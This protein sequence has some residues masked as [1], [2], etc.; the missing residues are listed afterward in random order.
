M[1]V[2]SKVTAVFHQKSLLDYLAGRF[3][4]QTREIWRA[5]IEAGEVTCNGRSAI[6]DQ[7]VRQGDVIACDLPEPPLPDADL[8]YKVVY[9][10]DW[11]LAVNKPGNLKVHGHGRFIQANLVYQLRHNHTPPYPEATL[12]N[13]LDRDTSGVVLLARDADTLRAVQTQFAERTVE[14]TYLAVVQGIPNWE[15]REVDLPIGRLPSAE[16][17]YRFG[18]LE[19]GKSAQTVVELVRPFPPNHALVRLT[20]KT[21]RTHQLRVHLAALGHPIVGDRLYT[22]SDADYLAWCENKASDDAPL[23]RHALHCAQ[24]TIWHPH[25]ERPLTFTAPLAPDIHTFLQTLDP[26]F[27]P[28]AS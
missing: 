16:G 2:S 13:R 6:P 10:D 14:K 27:D 20:P 4:Y 9:E 21:G 26:S 17:V 28:T 19:D 5:R 18:V 8:N 3:T 25:E 24:T 7:I 22:M 1:I 23:P 15:S 12:I 11:L